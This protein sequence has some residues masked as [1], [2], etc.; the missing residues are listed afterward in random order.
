MPVSAILLACPISGLGPQTLD[1][2]FD[3]RLFVSEIRWPRKFTEHGRAGS[4]PLGHEPLGHDATLSVLRLT[5]PWRAPIAESGVSR[6][7]PGKGGPSGI[8]RGETASS[9]TNCRKQ[10][11]GGPKMGL[12]C[13]NAAG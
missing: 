9:A 12:A 1:H 8:A 4:V 11:I 6:R 2:V 7:P 10:R 5:R 13:A 3:L